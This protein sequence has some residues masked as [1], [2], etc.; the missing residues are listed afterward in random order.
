VNETPVYSWRTFLD[1][2]VRVE[3][4]FLRQPVSLIVDDPAPGY[5]PAHFHSG[6]RSGPLQ[7]PPDLID[8]FADL[9]DATGIRGKFS[10]VPYPFGL[11]R[12]DRAVQGVSDRD[13]EHFLAVT[14]ERIAPAMDITPEVLTHWN[15]LDLRTGQLLPYWEHVWSR[16]Q[17]KETLLPYMS[18]ALE[19]LNAVDLPCSGMTSPWNFGAGVEDSYAEALLAAQQAVNGRSVTWYFLHSDPQ[20]TTVPPRLSVLRPEAG[21]AVVSLVCCDAADFARPLWQGE[22]PR[23]QDLIGEDGRSGRLAEVIAAGGPAVFHTHWQSIFGYGTDRGLAALRTIAA[24][25]DQH[26]GARLRWIGC[27]DLAE[28]AATAAS[29]QVGAPSPG[30]EGS[31]VW[32][33]QALLSCHA[34]TL[35]I[36]RAAPVRE[37]RIAGVPLQRVATPALLREGTYLYE[38]GRLSLCWTPA[39]SQAIEVY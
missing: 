38:H 26:F 21:Q 29:V 1:G 33:V 19:I 34:F 14:R 32:Q 23:P 12:V 7:V 30:N 9:L 25:L 2:S 24:R 16:S 13:L 10:V 31:V 4:P 15:A 22:D 35:S 17:T 36:A 27:R 8:R 20:A 6:F 11:G 18:L 5:N 28:Y 39:G 37:V 3:H